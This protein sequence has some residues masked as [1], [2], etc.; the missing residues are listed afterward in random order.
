[1]PKINNPRPAAVYAPGDGKELLAL[2]PLLDERRLY[3]LD[4]RT[5]TV[6]D[7]VLPVVD[8]P[9][10]RLHLLFVRVG[11]EFGTDIFVADHLTSLGAD[12]RE[13][14][15]V[16]G[17]FLQLGCEVVVDGAELDSAWYR[18]RV[19][20]L[21][22]G[23]IGPLIE[24]LVSTSTIPPAVLEVWRSDPDRGELSL[25]PTSLHLRYDEARLRIK[26]LVE[27]DGLSH[28]EAAAR[29]MVEG[30]RNAD[31]RRIWYPKAVRDALKKGL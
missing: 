18:A 30:Y 5:E 23:N 13:R 31:G 29:V 7:L 27:F 20:K 9:V 14:V 3:V 4:S 22:F 25:L 10:L 26:E 11:P 12:E 28:T 15:A 17:A 6:E 8:R 16:V 24:S 19:G 2:H 21:G 1:M